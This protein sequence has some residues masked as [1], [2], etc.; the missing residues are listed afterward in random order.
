MN[1][2]KMSFSPPLLLSITASIL[3]LMSQFTG[4]AG[5]DAPAR[6][7]G[8][9]KFPNTTKA[10]LESPVPPSRRGA[11]NGRYPELAPLPPGGNARSARPVMLGA[12]ERSSNLE[13]I[14]IDEKA[15]TVRIKTGKEEQVLSLD[16]KADE[17]IAGRTL[18]LQSAHSSLIWDIYQAF[19][20]CTVL[21]PPDLPEVTVDVT[22]GPGLSPQEVVGLLT[23]ALAA[24]GVGM[25]PMGGKFVVAFRQEAA[26]KLAKLAPPPQPN[27]SG[28]AG[29]IDPVFPPGL[30]KFTSAEAQQALDIYQ[31]LSGRTLIIQANP[32]GKIT[33]RSQTAMSRRE[34]V[35]MLETLFLLGGLKVVAEGELFAYVFPA[36]HEMKLPSFDAKAMAEKAKSGFAPGTMVLKCVDA[37]PEQLLKLYAELLGREALPIERNVPPV[38]LSIRGQRVMEKAQ[39]AFALE[40]LAAVNNLRFEMVGEKVALASRQGRWA[41]LTRIWP[42]GSA[43][44]AL[45]RADLSFTL[46]LRNPSLLLGVQQWFQILETK[47]NAKQSTKDTHVCPRDL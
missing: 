8:I 9:V 40:A 45:D 42:P 30:I 7:T 36:D 28:Q 17:A 12:G 32:I 25:Q 27:P 4:G 2:M 37:L 33:V 3:L 19:C 26:G 34:A 38:R 46:A 24:K 15:G 16:Q 5:V 39:A 44:M 35:W 31:E 20:E 22:S 41:A 13:V 23:G 43:R 10:L 47:L 18:Q 6:L 14:A 1:L 11:G 29:P 21:L